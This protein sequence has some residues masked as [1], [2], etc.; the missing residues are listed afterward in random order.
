MFAIYSFIFRMPGLG[1]KN[2]ACV[3]CDK[4]TKPRERRKISKPE[5]RFL[6]K[7]FLVTVKHENDTLCN[8]CRHKYYASENKLLIPVRKWRMTTAS[9]RQNAVGLVLFFQ[10]RN[11]C[12]CLFR[13][14]QGV[15]RTA[16][17]ASAQDQN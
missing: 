6:Q 7:L 11:L 13:P 10:V 12:R 1:P 16:F 3:L 4:R 5:K 17:C 2:F 8:K 14:H 9:Q 15:T